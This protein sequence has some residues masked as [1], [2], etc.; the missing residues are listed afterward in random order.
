MAYQLPNVPYDR[1][2]NTDDARF[3]SVH[4]TNL[5]G[6]I[7]TVTTSVSTL[8]QQTITE[9]TDWYPGRTYCDC[10]LKIGLSNGSIGYIPVFMWG[11]A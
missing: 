3:D 5:I 6:L 10:A 1:V 8:G 4:V 2:L 11:E 9:R 7:S